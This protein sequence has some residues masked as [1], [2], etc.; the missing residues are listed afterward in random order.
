MRPL[1]FAV[2]VPLELGWLRQHC[3]APCVLFDFAQNRWRQMSCATLRE[4]ASTVL[5][6][7]DTNLANGQRF[8]LMQAQVQTQPNAGAMAAGTIALIGAATLGGAWFFQYVLGIQPCPM[9]LEQRYA[10]YLVIVLGAVLAFAASRLPRTLVIA[11]LAVL[12]L[13]AFG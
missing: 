10:Y 3:V 13:A 8:L 9:C 4:A 11:L 6:G 1:P 12:A 5:H 2:D 7:R